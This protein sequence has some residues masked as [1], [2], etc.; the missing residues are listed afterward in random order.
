[1]VRW[2]LAVGLL[3]AGTP[4][5]A[6]YEFDPADL[7]E[8]FVC[9]DALSEEE[10][11]TEKRFQGWYEHYNVRFD[12]WQHTLLF[13][14]NNYFAERVDA[15]REFN[16]KLSYHDHEEWLG[17][18]TP[19]LVD[20]FYSIALRRGYGWAFAVNEDAILRMV[21]RKGKDEIAPEA[22][23][24]YIWW[25]PTSMA[26]TAEALKVQWTFQEA[27][28][29]KCGGAIAHLRAFPAQ[30]R[31]RLWD[32]RAL[33][34]SPDYEERPKSENMYITLDGD[35]VF[36][37]AK[38]V[39]DQRSL[40]RIAEPS[41]VVYQQWNGGAGY[42]WAKRMEQIVRPCLKPSEATAPWE[43]YLTAAASAGSDV[44]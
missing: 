28:L 18:R 22:L 34:W 36:V 25:M 40:K 26:E 14:T 16:P 11:A 23:E 30:G 20:A 9:D 21:R 3:A 12:Y 39:L 43:M 8:G 5:V 19:N 10:C 32:E 35:G 37:R 29:T 6:D 33:E 17:Y 38:E 1:M 15:S 42:D 44:P 13:D 2:L 41:F 27:D 31:P 4:A 7:P 24:R